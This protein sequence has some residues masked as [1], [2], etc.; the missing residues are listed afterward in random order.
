MTNTPPPPGRWEATHK[1]TS[2]PGRRRLPALV[3]V[4]LIALV[5]A[6]GLAACSANTSGSTDAAAPAAP[7]GAAGGEKAFEN[8][9]ATAAEP[10]A[11]ADSSNQSKPGDPNQ[12]P[13]KVE[14]QLRALI[15]TGT[16]SVTVD[17]VSKAADQAV[18][19]ADGLSGAVGSD[20]RTLDGDRSHAQIVLRVPSDK[21]TAAL[22]ALSKLGT[23]NSR[24]VETQ[25]VT[26]QLVD[27]DARV[28]TQRAS[29]ERVR[30]LLAK[31]QTNSELL[32]IE[33]E[34]TRRQADLDSLLQRQARLSGLVALST[35]TAEL[36]GKEAPA[37]VV[38]P[39]DDTGFLAGLR[40]GWSAFL[41][42]IKVVLV[43]A[44]WLL[45]WVAAL[46]L[47]TWA[48]LWFLRRRNRP[49]RTTVISTN[50]A[51]SAPPA[52]VP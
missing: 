27:L 48:V 10:Q 41:K 34:V 26:E 31:A 43:I 14:P 11:P 18:D 42:S 35:I 30:E 23:E 8:G 9:G 20:A 13:A 12:A 38:V 6:G 39:E 17:N 37:T 7:A 3:G 5:T 40:E 28:A 25:D 33:S 2:A 24:K 47:P 19:I 21:F 15:Y 51:A 29:L 45:P 52:A 22:A 46:G 50:E 16:I 36:T 1:Y 4:G 44:G 32:S 49:A